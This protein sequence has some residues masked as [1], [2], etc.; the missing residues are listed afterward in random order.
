NSGSANPY[1]RNATI[2]TTVTNDWNGVTS[3]GV[4]AEW[5]AE[6]TEAADASPTV[7]QLKVTPQKADAYIFGSQ[8]FEMDSDFASQL[9]DLIAD[10]KDRL[11]EAAF[12]VGTGTGQPKGVVPAGTTLAAATGSVANGAAVA[13]VTSLMAALPARWRTGRANNRWLANLTTINNLR[14]KAAFTNATVPLIVD[15][16]TGPTMFGKPVEESTSIAGYGTNANKFLVWLDFYQ[17]YIVDRI[18]MSVIFDPVVIGTNRRPTGQQAWY[19]F[20][21]VGADVTTATAV[22]VLTA[23]T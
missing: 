4:N 18:G 22:R 3:A 16:P 2:K 13:D 21:R 9:P 12:A 7:G 17:Y 14:T 1:R 6:G 10:A 20:W 8:E 5:T 19:A 15:T 11:E 23:T